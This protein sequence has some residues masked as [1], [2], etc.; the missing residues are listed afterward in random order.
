MRR[1]NTWPDN[2]LLMCSAWFIGR[3]I[4]IIS[5]NDEGYS[6]CTRYRP[7]V[8]VN[9][10]QCMIR[11]RYQLEKVANSGPELF[12]GYIQNTHYQALVPMKTMLRDVECSRCGICFRI[13]RAHLNRSPICR[14]Y[15]NIPDLVKMAET[16]R[17]SEQR[18]TWLEQAAQQKS[19]E[20]VPTATVRTKNAELMWQRQEK[21]R[22]KSLKRARM[23]RRKNRDKIRVK[24]REYRERNR[25]KLRRKSAIYYKRWVQ[26]L[27]R[28]KKGR[29]R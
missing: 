24:S 12:L 13:L 27:E 15:Y 23:Y 18:K 9:P 4:V 25:E 19:S 17:R 3:N 7:E 5:E 16:V 21:I 11:T 28:R 14:S 6:I 10:G 20:N 1:P 26:K 2:M 8:M 29:R 22:M